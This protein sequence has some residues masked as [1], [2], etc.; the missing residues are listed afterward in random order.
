MFARSYAVGNGS[1]AKVRV[2]D[3]TVF[4]FSLSACAMISCIFFGPLIVADCTQS[5]SRYQNDSARIGDHQAADISGSNRRQ[6]H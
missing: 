6:R 5:L 3:V 2:I 4:D 1:D